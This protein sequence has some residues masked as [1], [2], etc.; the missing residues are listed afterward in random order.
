MVN[1]KKV[2]I[3]GFKMKKFKLFMYNF[4]ETV[5]IISA[6]S[7]IQLAI[8]VVVAL[9]S[10]FS[11]GST[12]SYILFNMFRFNLRAAT[13]GFIAGFILYACIYGLIILI[14]PDTFE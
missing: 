1:K 10:G 3:G 5:V 7:A 12:G 4:Y 6:F 11:A 13:Q 14:Y 2:I 9:I 8:P